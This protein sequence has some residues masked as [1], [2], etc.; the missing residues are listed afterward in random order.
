M[1]FMKYRRIWY[2]V[3]ALL[4]LAGITSLSLKG[5]NRGIDFT[6]GN[7]FEFRTSD[8]AVDSG[9]VR[10]A[11]SMA[12]LTG[13]RVQ[14]IGGGQ[15]L[16]RTPEM[17]E[18]EA[19]GVMGAVEERI[20]ELEVIRNERVGAV[21]GRELSMNAL[22]GLAIACALMILYIT[23]RFEFWFAV[24]A[25]V[26]LIHDV[27]VATGVVSLLQLQIDGAFVAAVLTIIGYSINDTI[28]VYDRIR[29]NLK[30]LRKAA[31]DEIVNLSIRQTLRRSISTSGTVAL[32]LLALL[33]FGGEST[34]VFAFT[35]LAGTIVGTYSSICVASPLW[36]DLTELLGRRRRAVARA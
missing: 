20:G 11:F 17:S 23:V 13:I 28:V 8:P 5:L 19:Q 21:I 30:N 18:E 32:A 36:L 12:G 29:E 34:K 31:P 9:R 27:L 1:D 7:V 6:G 4:I 16:V 22:I 10:E 26:A 24:A 14:V 15:F 25:I 3:S 2:I 35:L 33:I